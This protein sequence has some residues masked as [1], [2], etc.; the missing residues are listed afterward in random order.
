VEN[1]NCQ[2]VARVRK[3]THPLWATRLLEPQLKSA[4]CSLQCFINFFSATLATHFNCLSGNAGWLAGWVDG[5]LEPLELHLSLLLLRMKHLICC[6]ACAC[7]NKKSLKCNAPLDFVHPANAPLKS[8]RRTTSLASTVLGGFG[9]Q[10]FQGLQ[11]SHCPSVSG[12]FRV[13]FLGSWSE[14]L[15]TQRP[16][17]MWQCQW[18]WKVSV[19]AT[20][21]S[22][23]C[24]SVGR[25]QVSHCRTWELNLLINEK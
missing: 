8:A 20:S 6:T 24:L 17:A 21:G 23:V 18:Q 1:W 10:C 16:G 4:V 3:H 2:C 7:H 19:S 14:V 25:V 9:F 13:V 5:Y 15:R 11:G 12:V 22:L